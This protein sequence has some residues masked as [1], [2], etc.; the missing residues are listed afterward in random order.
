MIHVGLQFDFPE[1][2]RLHICFFYLGFIHHL[3]CEDAMGYLFLSEVNIAKST[4]SQLFAKFELIDCQLFLYLFRSLLLHA[5]FLKQ[6]EFVVI[7]L[8]IQCGMACGFRQNVRK[9]S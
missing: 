9:L 2:L 4:T 1:D 6:S 5:N 3:Y 8:A 7:H